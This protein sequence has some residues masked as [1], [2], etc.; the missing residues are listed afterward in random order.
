MC[1]DSTLF[2]HHHG[3]LF[4][5]WVKLIM[6][7]KGLLCSS[8]VFPLKQST[9]IQTAQV[10][11]RLH[12]HRKKVKADTWWSRVRLHCKYHTKTNT[13]FYWFIFVDSCDFHQSKET[14]D[15]HLMPMQLKLSELF[16]VSFCNLSSLIFKPFATLVKE[17]KWFQQQLVVGWNEAK[18]YIF[19][20]VFWFLIIFWFHAHQ[21]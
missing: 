7:P 3:L 8:N 1:P 11:P 2:V 18:C 20:F 9:V 10:Q 16:P 13:S 12:R 19:I 4:S 5:E 21:K 6:F 15:A 14:G 17:K